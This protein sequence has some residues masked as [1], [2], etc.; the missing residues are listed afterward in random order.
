[1]CLVLSYVHFL[2]YR[3]R[4]HMAIEAYRKITLIKLGHKV[5]HTR[6]HTH[7]ES[8]TN[9]ITTNY[10]VS[11]AHRNVLTTLRRMCMMITTGQHGQLERYAT[12]LAAKACTTSIHMGKNGVYMGFFC[13]NLYP[14]H[15]DIMQQSDV[16]NTYGWYRSPSKNCVLTACNPICLTTCP[17]SYHK[18]I[19]LALSLHDKREL[20]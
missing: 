10:G 7:L 12:T 19:M 11:H 1:M 14:A 5:R 13:A 9:L 15:S 2:K 18:L 8:Q 16:R 17:R 3:G 6:G 4:I 20:R